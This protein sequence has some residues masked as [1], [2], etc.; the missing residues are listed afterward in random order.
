MGLFY[1]PYRTFFAL[2]RGRR[3]FSWLTFLAGIIIVFAETY[4]RFQF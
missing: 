4:R 1:I 2:G 3:L